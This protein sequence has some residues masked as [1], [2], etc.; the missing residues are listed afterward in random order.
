MDAPQ[1]SAARCRGVGVLPHIKKL[2][3]ALSH[4]LV[5]ITCK[6]GARRIA[7]PEALARVCGPS[8]TLEAVGKRM[9]CSKWGTK[10]AEVVAVARLRPR[11]GGYSGRREQ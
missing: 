3:D 10:G 8:A 2:D 5:Q 11:G 7:E 9:R 6:C 4:F 1:G